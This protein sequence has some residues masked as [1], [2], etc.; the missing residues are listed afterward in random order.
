MRVNEKKSYRLRNR[1]NYFNP[2][3]SRSFVQ[4]T[5]PD[6]YQSRR[7]K[8]E[9][10]ESRLFWQF[11]YCEDHDGQTFFYTLTY[12]DEAMPK[13]QGEN[14]FD[15]EDLR[16]LL[17]GA[18]K[19]RLL[20]QY[21]TNV[22]Y[23]VGA[24]LGDGKGSRGLH[25]NPHYHVLF[26]LEPA[27]SER[28]PYQKISKKD[29]RHLVREYWQ[30]FDQ[31]VD[32]RTDFKQAKFGIAKEGE[33]LGLVGDFRACMYC[34]KYVCKD[35]KLK[36]REGRV[37][38]SLERKYAREYNYENQ[39]SKYNPLMDFY[40]DF[41]H[42][43]LI[44]PDPTKLF[45]FDLVDM[46]FLADD[47]LVTT[48][49]IQLMIMRYE[50]GDEF[51]RY[52]NWKRAELVKQEFN[53]YRNRFC[54]KCRISQGVGD[55][56]LDFIDDKLHPR[57]KM[58]KKN[59]WKYRPIGMYYYRKLYTDVVK[60]PKGNNLRVLNDLGK[61]YKMANLQK[62]L[63]RIANKAMTNLS[64]L[65]KDLYDKMLHSDVNTEI[66]YGYTYERFTK[67][68][69]NNDVTEICKRYAEYKLI[70][71]D[72]FFQ[73]H[74]DTDTGDC[75]FPDINP[76]ADYNRFIQ[77]SYFEVMYR[78]GRLDRFLESIPEN[79]I[80]YDAH[81]YFLSYLRLFSVLDLIADYL[82]VQT[83]NKNQSDAEEMANTKRFHDKEKLREF[84]S[85]F[86]L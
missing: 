60:D 49:D 58:P 70:Y 83:D 71:E 7:Q 31:D 53:E 38:L 75:G 37:R 65:T 26:F 46:P 57:I 39:T 13:Y 20:R 74:V 42:D 22:K 4:F 63:D 77:P 59:G 3:T 84:Y 44:S 79:Y 12:N 67:D 25:N 55:Y 40:H 50:L 29:F 35:A 23:F 52:V 54:N 81:S 61:E 69:N 78:P 11:K 72:R 9:G 32:G 85:Q 43:F 1:T 19:K 8:I 48:Y 18:F 82:F 24:E 86:G 66:R 16:Y 36:K 76:V 14:C 15:Y 62:Q 47:S 41:L 28:Y 17:N 56:A 64:T 2:E 80:S 5:S 10:Y 68:L 21:G 73:F 30:G 51:A 6:S 34:A 45:N 27:N 33:N